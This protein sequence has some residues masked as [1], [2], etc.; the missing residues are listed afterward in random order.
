MLLLKVIIKEVKLGSDLLVKP[1]QNQVLVWAEE[2]VLIGRCK[3]SQA[4]CLQRLIAGL[5][6]EML[7]TRLKVILEYHT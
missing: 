7:L 1:P 6:P 2:L 4:G 3:D 5:E